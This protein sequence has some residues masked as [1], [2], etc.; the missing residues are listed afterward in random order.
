MPSR[1]SSSK[2]GKGSKAAACSKAGSARAEAGRVVAGVVVLSITADG[3]EAAV[4]AG[5]GMVHV[6]WFG[7]EKRNS[8]KWEESD[9]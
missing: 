2:T 8:E 6:I 1:S 3:V 4:E 9:I 5:G 7:T